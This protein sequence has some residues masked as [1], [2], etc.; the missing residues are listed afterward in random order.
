MPTISFP[1]FS[2]GPHLRKSWEFGIIRVVWSRPPCSKRAGQANLAGSWI[3]LPL[4]RF[5]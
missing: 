4:E 5:V 1:S 3:T 2:P